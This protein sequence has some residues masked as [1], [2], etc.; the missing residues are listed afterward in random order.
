MNLHFDQITRSITFDPAKQKFHFICG[1]TE[2]LI[3][4][5][6]VVGKSEENLKG[7]DV[8]VM[9]RVNPTT[10]E[11]IVEPLF[12]MIRC[13]RR[14]QKVDGFEAINVA[15]RLIAEQLSKLQL[16]ISPGEILVT[17]GNKGDEHRSLIT[18]I[19]DRANPRTRALVN[20]SEPK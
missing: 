15:Y 8:R 5:M 3:P 13:I 2:I 7:N 19:W 10:G 20:A 18:K 11:P 12:S 9:F 6:R 17:V 4:E 16:E 1:T 14:E